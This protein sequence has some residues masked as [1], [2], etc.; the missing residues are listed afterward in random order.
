MRLI[1]CSGGT[2][3]LVEMDC[4]ETP[5]DAIRPALTVSRAA[6]RAR[7]GDEIGKTSRDFP[8]LQR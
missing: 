1:H 2:W 8:I 6:Q 4:A 3:M 5:L 7:H